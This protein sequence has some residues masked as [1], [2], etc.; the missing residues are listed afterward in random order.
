[1]KIGLIGYG[2]MGQLIEEISDSYQCQVAGKGKIEDIPEDVDVYIDFSHPS[3]VKKNVLAVLERKKPMVMGTS[4][5]YDSFEEIKNLIIKEN[6]GFI[7]AHNFSIGVNLFMDIVGQAAALLDNEEEFDVSGLEIHHNQ[8]HD[9]PSGT[10]IALVQELLS[11]FSRKKRVNYERCDGKIDTEVIHFASL[12]SGYNP[13]MHQVI[14]DSP[15]ESIQ[16]TL[17]SKNRLGYAK[18][19]LD[20]AKWIK[21]RKGFFN[22]KEIF[23]G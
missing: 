11:R 14:F 4:G 22:F 5:W 1:M 12:R 20:A 23:A 3:S 15:F 16:L 17:Q 8:K 18:G 6:T 19:A 21:D 7:Y 13:G 9:S 10:A 2:K